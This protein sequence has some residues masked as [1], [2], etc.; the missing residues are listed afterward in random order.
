MPAHKFEEGFPKS[1]KE[2]AF[3][4]IMMFFEGL[5]FRRELL[6]ELELPI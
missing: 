6:P 5:P 3:A 2:E 1:D 4:I